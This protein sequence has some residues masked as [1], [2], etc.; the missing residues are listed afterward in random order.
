[1]SD[2]FQ[3]SIKRGHQVTLSNVM[4]RLQ[5]GQVFSLTPQEKIDL[6]DLAGALNYWAAQTPASDAQLLGHIPEGDYARRVFAPEAGQV[7][8]YSFPMPM[9]PCYLS[10][11]E[12]GGDPWLRTLSVS[13]VLGDMN[14]AHISTGKQAT[15]H[16]DL[17]AYP[18]GM[19]LYANQR[20]DEP[21]PA[22]KTGSGFSIVW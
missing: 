17:D 7:I 20:I 21:A 14:G 6:S 18:P 11:A 5:A 13:P 19:L 15:V 4:G 2:R 1:M 8:A 10:A 9:M 3:A 22:G 16:L 12:F